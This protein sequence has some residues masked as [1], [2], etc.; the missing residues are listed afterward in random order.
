MNL[1]FDRRRCQSKPFGNLSFDL[2]KLSRVEIK[3]NILQIRIK[4][5]DLYPVYLPLS[6]NLSLNDGIIGSQLDGKFGV[7]GQFGVCV[8]KTA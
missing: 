5:A 4:G 6:V 8:V 2:I 1:F 3:D 7:G